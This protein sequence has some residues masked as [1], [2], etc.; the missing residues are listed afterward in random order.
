MQS[1]PGLVFELSGDIAILRLDRP[2]RGN[3]LDAVIE[4]GCKEAWKEVRE[5]PA[6]R[7]AV[8]T[9][10]GE[11]H[12]CTGGDVSSLS[13][14]GDTALVNKPYHEAVYFSSLQNRVF[15]PVVCAVNGL[16][17]GAGLHFVVDSD[18]IVASENATFLDTH[19]NVGQ[20]GAIE[21]IGLMKRLPIGTAL[22]MTL[23]GKSY[24]LTAR[25]AYELGMVDELVPAPGDA[26]PKALAIARE[27]AANSPQAVA[28]SKQALWESLEQGYTQACANGWNL[29]RT[30]WSHPDFVEG[31][32]AFGE[33]RA[34][35]WNPDPNARHKA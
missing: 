22:R 16:A 1:T 31:P 21:N 2:D 10:T 5:N 17:C 29:I 26:L 18:I 30:Q 11:R 8:I 32:R 12:F 28:L 24:R 13:T 35:A 15:K 25:R 23:Q 7:A 27:I 9:G 20:V 19:V 3:A 6:I 34:P 33:R 4:R 14:D